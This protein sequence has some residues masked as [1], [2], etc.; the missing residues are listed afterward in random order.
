MIAK[1]LVDIKSK[2]VDKTYDYNIPPQFIGILEIGAR[3]IVPFG[4]RSVMGFCLEIA[5]NSE[6]QNTLKNIDRIIDVEP[7]LTLELIELAK[8]MQVQSSSLLIQ[9]FQTMLPAALKVVYKPKIEAIHFEEL[10]QELQKVFEYSEEL[11]LDSI[12]PELYPIIKQQIRKQNLKQIYDIKPKNRSLAFKYVKLTRKTNEGLTPKQHSVFAYLSTQK[13][14]QA[15]LKMLLE[16]LNIT[17]SVINTMEKN[18]YLNTFYKETYREIKPLNEPKSKSIILNEDQEIAFQKIKASFGT[19]KTFLLHGITGSGKTEIYIK[20]IQ[21]VVKRNQSV[22]FLVPEIS[23]TPMM[24]SR[25]K[26]EFKEQ[27]AV[28]HSGLSAMEKYDEWRR[29]VRKEATIVVGARSACFAPVED[30]GLIIVDE[31]HESSYKQDT[32]PNYYA[33][34]VLMRRSASEKAV[35]ILGSA[36]PNIESY[37]RYIRGYFELLTLDKRALNAKLPQVEVVDMKQEF[38]Q[39]NSSSFSKSLQTEIQ[40]RLDRKEQVILLLNRRGY[41][42]FIIC[43]NC[44]HVFMCPNCDVSLTYHEH[45]HSLKCHYCNHDEPMPKTCTKCG[46][47][48]LRYMGSGTQRVETELAQLFPTANIIR[49]DND[50]T[51]TK[52]AHERL[53]HE[54]ETTGDI[55]LGTQMIAKGL[56]FPNVTLVGI[57]QADANLY[58]S[59]FRASEKTFQLIMQVSGRA[60]RRDTEGKVV[61]QAFNPEH[62]AIRFACESDYLGFYH[63]EMNIRRLAKYAPFYFMVELKVMGPNIRD[64]FYNGI[65]IVKFLKRNFDKGTIVLGPAIPVVRRINNRYLCEI[66]IK[67]RENEQIDTILGQMMDQYQMQDNL[68]HID[69]F[70]NVG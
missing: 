8:E 27:V 60:G 14:K 1:I 22:L 33:I 68:I 37:A 65:E 32:T 46:S 30:L 5:E 24:M 63:H 3:V 43:R 17:S 52:N 44:G 9:I 26:A 25:L 67:Y 12:D 56:D 23:L 47:D 35:L 2:N 41:S 4:N 16:V 21:E 15:K 39:G 61:I 49:M 18:G 38:I 36:T 34:D 6:Y 64:V 70:P 59:D 40:S 50:T 69:R 28:L 10:P 31:C 42:N 19:E 29:I 11:M 58:V 45:S 48:A 13:N 66:M 55:L 62:Y 53:L 54:F 20:S 57:I 7:Y 51:R